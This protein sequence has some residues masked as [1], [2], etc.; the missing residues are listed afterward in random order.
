MLVQDDS[1]H[2]LDIKGHHVPLQAVACHLDKVF[3]LV[4]GVLQAAARL[5]HHG[6]RLAEDVVGGLAIPEPL[7]ELGGLGLEL[8]VAQG[9]VGL[10]QLVD[11]VDQRPELVDNALVTAAEELL[12]NPIEKH[13][14]EMLCGDMSDCA[15]PWA[16]R[17]NGY[18][19][20]PRPCRQPGKAGS[21]QLLRLSSY[22]D[23]G[24]SRGFP[25]AQ[26]GHSAGL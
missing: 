13:A 16:R 20:S 3:L 7:L 4:G 23:P 14:S 18:T 19:P 26:T 25:W 8:L 10:R 17:R 6:I 22:F 9:L 1:A 21:G 15:C 24:C 12:Y 11:P 5:L 2:D